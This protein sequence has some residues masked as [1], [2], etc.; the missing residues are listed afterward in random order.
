MK[1]FTLQNIA[2]ILQQPLARPEDKSK[3]LSKI[4]TDTRVLTKDC[5]FIA[6]S[7]ENFDGH[8]YVTTALEQGALYA[9]VSEKRKSYPENIFVVPDT[10]LAYLAIA[11]AWRRQMLA[12]IVAVTG[13]VGKTSTKDMV[14]CV[15]ESQFTTLKTEENLNNEVGV[16]Q[17]LLSLTP[18][19]QAAVLE[20]GVDGPEQMAPMAKA[21][22]PNIA[23]VTNIGQSHLAA[24]GTQEKIA[25]EKLALAAGLSQN[26][27]L[28]LSGDDAVLRSKKSKHSNTL[29]FG[30][31]QSDCDILA[32]NIQIRE[33]SQEFE[34]IYNNTPYPVTIPT[35]GRHMIYNA[36]AGFGAG[37]LLG[38]PPEQAAQ[39]LGKYQPTGM[40]Q[41]LVPFADML[42]VE[43]CYNAN[44]Q[45]MQSAMETLGTMERTG[46]KVAILSD[47]LELGETQQQA[48]YQLGE[49]VAKVG[50][51]VLLSTGTLSQE[52]VQG[53]LDK[54]LSESY[55]FPDKEALFLFLKKQ[56]QP[57]DVL[58]FK[59]S[60]GMR[61]ETII[62][63]LYQECGTL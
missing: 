13:S 6:L 38:V 14:A 21:V 33:F 16:S 23:I 25:E 50:I 1:P 15:L 58:W 42:V 12:H 24:F 49:L 30:I 18:E 5:L 7:G 2:E 57:G 60:R 27:T 46:R 22:L 52:T 32:R 53:A 43:D 19:H 59:A 63:Q 51:D 3:R 40:R 9:V 62:Q 48:H 56:C 10:R 41:K 61:L 35:L 39:A 29:L 20:L 34:I 4:C 11:G 26:G 28:L 44:P 37:V 55:H 17:M 36:L 54:G 45:S 47:M 31:E 8:D